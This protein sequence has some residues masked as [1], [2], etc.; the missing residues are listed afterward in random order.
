MTEARATLQDLFD[1]T[2]RRHTSDNVKEIYGILD[3]YED[4]LQTL[5]ADARYETVVAPYFEALDPIRATVKKSNDPKAS[6]KGKDDLF[7]EASGAL[8]DNMEELMRLLD[9]Q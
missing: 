9:S 2:P 4:L 1:R 8:K 6:K 7:D 5:E 3:A